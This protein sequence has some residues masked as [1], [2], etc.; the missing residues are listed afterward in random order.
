MGILVPTQTKVDHGWTF[1]LAS[2]V[3]YIINTIKNFSLSFCGYIV[4]E[5][6]FDDNKLCPWSNTA[7]SRVITSRNT[8]N[9]RTVTMHIMCS[10]YFLSVT[11]QV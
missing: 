11:I 8:S 10:F 4:N 3:K 2:N 1:V 7:I 5:V 9:M 6:K